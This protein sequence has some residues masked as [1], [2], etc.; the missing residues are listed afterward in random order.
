MQTMKR[1]ILSMVLC[2]VML[3]GMIPTA[4]FAT[5]TEETTHTCT[6]TYTPTEDGTQHTALCEGCG[7]SHVED[8]DMADGR[9]A[10][11]DWAPAEEPTIPAS[12]ESLPEDTTAPQETV[13]GETTLPTETTVVTEPVEATE[14]T[15]ATEPTE[16]TDSTEPVCPHENTQ[17]AAEVP[18]TCEAPGK[19]AGTICADCGA[20]VTGGEDLPQLTHSF[21]N[22]VCTL[23]QFAC[24]HPETEVREETEEHAAGT[25]CL[26]CGMMLPES[27]SDLP[28]GFLGMPQGYTLSSAQIE[29]KE[30]LVEND[31]L[32]ALAGMEG[33]KDYVAG[34]IMFWA[35]TEEEARAIAAAYN[36]KLSSY[37][38]NI[39]EATLQG[40]TVAQAL[41]VAMDSENNMPAVDPI[42]R[43]TLEPSLDLPHYQTGQLESIGIQ[44]PQIQVWENFKDGDPFLTDPRSP[45]YQWH[46]DM[47]NTYEA[48]GVT[49]GDGVTVA[50]LDS[51]VDT[52]HPD[53]KNQVTV[54]ANSTFPSGYSSDHGTA[55]AGVIAAIQGNGQF[56]AGV[57]PEADILSIRITSEADIIYDSTLAQAI[58]AA[59]N[60]YVDIIN[61]SATFLAKPYSSATL[62]RA[63]DYAYNRNITI[64]AA[65]GNQASNTKHA[66]ACLNHV[67]AVCAVAPDGYLAQFSNYG[68]WA[69]LSAPGYHIPVCTPGGD[70]SYWIG[71]SM[72]SPMA[73]GVAALYISAL[74]YNPGPD[75]V[76][77]AMKKAVNKGYGSS[78]MGKGI[79]DAAKLFASDRTAPY[80]FLDTTASLNT[81]ALESGTPDLSALAA[82]SP[83]ERDAH[84]RN[85]FYSADNTANA[86]ALTE[87][88]RS[89][90][91]LFISPRSNATN[92]KMLVITTD[93]SN[94]TV[95]NGVVTNGLC[96]DVASSGGW[97]FLDLEEFPSRTKVTIKAAYVSG[98]GVMSQIS[99]M[100]FTLHPSW[101]NPIGEVH[102]AG[103]DAL[104]APGKSLS[105]FATVEPYSSANQTVHWEI[106]SNYSAPGAKLSSKGVLTTKASDWGEIV[107]RATSVVDARVYDQITVRLTSQPLVKTLKLRTTAVTLGY[108]VLQGLSSRQLQVSEMTNVY[109]QSVLGSSYYGVTW[110]SSNPNV[111]SVDDAGK[112]TAVSLGK[113]TITCTAKDGSKKSAKCTVT[114]VTPPEDMEII[115]Q[116]DIGRGKKAS[117]KVDVY[118]SNASKSVT[119]ELYRM[120]E[121]TSTNSYDLYSPIGVSV[122]SKGVVTVSKSA[123]TQRLQ[124]RA[125][126]VTGSCTVSRTIWVWEPTAYVQL[127][128]NTTYDNIYGINWT[129]RNGSMN[130]LN[131]YSADVADTSVYDNIF[132]LT[133]YVS[134]AVGVTWTSSNPSVASI[135]S[136]GKITA[137]K[138]GSTTITCKANDG[139]GKKATLAVKVTTPASYITVK[140]SMGT[141]AWHTLGYGKSAT[142]KAT[143]GDTYGK[144]TSTKVNWSWAMYEIDSDGNRYNITSYAM[145]NK[146]V[147]LS[148]SGK[149]TISKN[150]GSLVDYSSYTYYVEV[151]ATAT[152]AQHTVTGQTT[153][154]IV[155][156]TTT[157]RFGT[158]SA[159]LPA[160]DIGETYSVAFYT[161]SAYINQT[162]SSSNPN[163]INV[164]GDPYYD[165]DTGKYYIDFVLAGKGTAKLTM[166]SND[167]SG[168]TATITIRVR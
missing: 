62:Q 10:L 55:V 49:Q 167:G 165:Y 77:A 120:V 122:N 5:E 43:S 67:I 130:T 161:D 11:C 27:D 168:K 29:S 35:D 87:N 108:G 131:L 72:A 166:K 109:G 86:A 117:Y 6:W 164:D 28:Y 111:V 40:A 24:T 44:A 128:R 95:K 13:A 30:F 97:F 141:Y 26:V 22:G 133:A 101:N 70:Y 119:W 134:S 152:Y 58:T 84:Y 89:N 99:V 64:F 73:A 162:V 32:T 39:G 159:T 115:G 25:Y 129:Y 57:A 36:A 116:S 150:M 155:R 9:C 76:E 100:T 112:I 80:I 69:D 31:C 78:Q 138:A 146:L 148:S 136:W 92:G 71:T 19:A 21:E 63:V 68:A 53:L 33:G 157:L 106:I 74:G 51:G 137:H 37:A 48:W 121:N 118:P 154:E 91:G 147:S 15:Q 125:R 113:A 79:I 123:P 14:A 163:V 144:P 140:S 126:S 52:S 34:T 41:E 124:L 145:R 20:Y 8:H 50:V 142:N 90:M 54:Y 12:E 56:G 83:E 127:D 135:T 88:A 60:R 45:K 93:G 85:A 158:S 102:I 82:M 18:A 7:E 107:I 96:Y 38:Y 104:L 47:L 110:K 156:P 143:L 98:M 103:G 66:P 3:V 151:Y 139:S 94:P 59:A 75:R 17:E 46:H 2:L 16:T 61:I 81:A 1:R 23:C 42:C 105:L 149:V 132:Y 65:M 160:Y 4:A 153:Y 114:V